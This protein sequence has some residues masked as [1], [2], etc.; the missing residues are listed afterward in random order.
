MSD[1][2]PRPARS[3]GWRDR[4]LRLAIVAA[5][6]LLTGEALAAVARWRANRAE[7]QELLRES[8]NDDAETVI[9]RVAFERTPHHAQ[10]ITARALVYEAMA[11]AGPPA[12]GKSVDRRLL[13]ARELALEVLRHQPNNWQASMFLGAATYLDWSQ[14]SDRR[15]YTEAARWEKPLQKAVREAAGRPEPRRFLATAYLETWAALSAE[16]RAFAAELLREAFR[17]DPG[18]FARM[19]PV[20]LETA[21]DQASALELIPDRPD[22]WRLLERT[23]AASKDWGSFSLVHS[24]YLDALERRL[25]DDLAEARERLRLGDLSGGRSLCLSVVVAAHRDG[26]FADLVSRA[27]RLYP[28]G[29]HGLRSAGPLREWLTWALELAELAVTPFSPRVIGRLT[30]AI[31]EL[32]PAEG[33]FAALI[34]DDVYR[35]QRYE[36]LA[37]SKVDAEWAPYLIAKSQWLV[38]RNDVALAERTLAEVHRSAH[39]G[40]PYWLARQR[41]ARAA[42]DLVVL[43]EA[44]RQ[45]SALQKTEWRPSDWRVQGRRATLEIYPLREAAGVATLS[46]EIL[47]APAGGAAIELAFDG[48]AVALR[49]AVPGATVELSLEVE[50]KPHRLE[51]RPLAGGEVY[52][53]RVR[54]SE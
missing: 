50:P 44:E 27:L 2:S 33:A 23:Y 52:P 21:D 15:L 42:G 28:P 53:G 47:S 46:I 14:R 7:L 11:A 3:G 40:A 24:R 49:P 4:L 6:L 43:G 20:W 36:R 29:I 48:T 34:A 17:D 1:P 16:K 30:D 39:A 12:G 32:E 19:A 10:L 13:R 26:R 54:L 31:G 38:D 8:A 5:C 25:E 18:A 41:V 51:L 37:D 45:L 35:I 22:A 9:R